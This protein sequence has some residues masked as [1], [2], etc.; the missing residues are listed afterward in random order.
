[1]SYVLD[2]LNATE[3]KEPTP[4]EIS[5]SN[6]LKNARETYH[7]ER[8]NALDNYDRMQQ[9]Y[10]LNTKQEPP[11]GRLT[12]HRASPDGAAIRPGDYVTS[13]YG[14]AKK[15]IQAN[16][17]GKGKIVSIRTHVSELHP[18]DG[19]TEFW[20]YPHDEKHYKTDEDEKEET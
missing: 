1:M 10:W 19:P 8:D 7:K 3:A 20:Y 6:R 11:D 17:G 9:R 14:Y 5:L 15:H 12:V 13:S 2:V 4:Y 16:M 18:A